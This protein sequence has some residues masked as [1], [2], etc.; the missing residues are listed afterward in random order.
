VDKEWWRRDN[1]V[2][3]FCIHVR[4]ENS[5]NCWHCSKK[6]ERGMKENNGEGWI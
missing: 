1:I 6:G 5:E 3:I 4:K 2:D